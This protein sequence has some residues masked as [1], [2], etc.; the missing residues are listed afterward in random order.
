MFD[1]QHLTIR[2]K[3]VQVEYLTIIEI[4]SLQNV[5]HLSL[6]KYQKMSGNFDENAA[7]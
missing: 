2:I 6:G 5:E 3:R 1:K 4:K 7:K